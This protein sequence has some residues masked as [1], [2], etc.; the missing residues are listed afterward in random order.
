MTFVHATDR[1]RGQHTTGTTGTTGARS[2]STK[3][4]VSRAHNGHERW[5][6]VMTREQ[7]VMAEAVKMADARRM[8][9]SLRSQSHDE[10]NARIPSEVHTS[11]DDQ[12]G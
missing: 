9:E 6:R 11:P 1:E 10:G 5:Q 7:L 3:A 2:G 8:A 12:D 4:E